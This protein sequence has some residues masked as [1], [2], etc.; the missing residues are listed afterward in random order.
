MFKVRV[1]LG[2]L[3]RGAYSAVF[4]NNLGQNPAY[5]VARIR[6][7]GYYHVIQCTTR[8]EDGHEI[9]ANIKKRRER[10]K[11]QKAATATEEARDEEVR[12]A[13]IHPERINLSGHMTGTCGVHR[14]RCL[15]GCQLW[16]RERSRFG[17][18]A[19]EKSRPVQTTSKECIKRAEWFRL[20]ARG[21]RQAN[22]SARRCWCTWTH[23]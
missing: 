10:A 12:S 17:G 5:P 20:S 7:F 3:R 16:K 23:L 2:Y 18:N 22:A 11:R 19:S 9:L 8:L 6:L 1:S 14:G 15:R 13:R 21:W 4:C